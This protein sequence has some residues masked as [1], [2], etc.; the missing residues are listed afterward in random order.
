LFEHLEGDLGAIVTP[1]LDLVYRDRVTVRLSGRTITGEQSTR[2]ICV[3][4]PGAFIILKALAFGMRGL[5]KDAY[6][7]L[8]VA[9]CST[10]RETTSPPLP[11]SHGAWLPCSTL[12]MPDEPSRSTGEN[13][14]GFVGSVEV[15]LL[16]ILRSMKSIPSAEERRCLT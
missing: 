3:C 11:R 5:P 7:M 4:G 14:L 13:P 9:I 10:W 2:D 8:Y 16:V 12:Q 15:G 1:G 6:D